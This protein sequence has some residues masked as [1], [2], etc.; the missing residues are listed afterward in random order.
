MG[1]YHLNSFEMGNK[2]GEMALEAIK[3]MS[4]K[5]S[6]FKVPTAPQSKKS[7]MKI[8]TEEKY[9]EVCLT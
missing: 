4:N 2:P 3:K 6:V 5:V 8:L 9:I 7:K 1:F